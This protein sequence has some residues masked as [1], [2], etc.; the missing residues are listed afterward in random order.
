MYNSY[1]KDNHMFVDHYLEEKNLFQL[2]TYKEI[3][4]IVGTF[5]NMMDKQF[6]SMSNY[7]QI[8]KYKLFWNENV[9]RI[10]H[11]TCNPCKYVTKSQ[12]MKATSLQMNGVNKR[13]AINETI[14]FYKISQFSQSTCIHSKYFGSKFGYSC[15]VEILDLEYFFPPSE[16]NI[17]QVLL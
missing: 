4:V 13:Y 14:P 2:L 15:F 12:V 10:M 9:T 1:F 6:V 8:E 17:L 7:Y 16:N 11:S 5:I 3:Y